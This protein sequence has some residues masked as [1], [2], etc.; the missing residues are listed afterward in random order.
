MRRNHLLIAALLGAAGGLAE[1]SVH[2]KQ[3][4]DRSPEES[5]QRLSKAQKKRERKAAQ[6]ARLAE[7]QKTT[8]EARAND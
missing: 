5:R 8:D 6:R 7:Q 2:P 1:P 4:E 3:K